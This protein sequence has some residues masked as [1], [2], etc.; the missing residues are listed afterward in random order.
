MKMNK[1]GRVLL[2]SKDTKIGEFVVTNL[3]NQVI[4]QT[5]SQNWRISYSSEMLVARIIKMFL[6]Q[7]N[8]ENIRAICIVLYNVTC[9]VPDEKHLQDLNA[10]ASACRERHPE[11]YDMSDITPEEDQKI[12]E[13]LKQDQQA[14]EMLKE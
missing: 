5:T 11:L 6:A 4:L 10:A 3:D 9:V 7:K 8:T 1:K 14:A 2:S 12:I 13:E